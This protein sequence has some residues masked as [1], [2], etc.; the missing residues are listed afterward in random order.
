MAHPTDHHSDTARHPHRRRAVGVF[1]A[2][3]S[4]LAFR[5]AGTATA[6]A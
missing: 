2:T 6:G 4:M 5:T 1:V 3:G